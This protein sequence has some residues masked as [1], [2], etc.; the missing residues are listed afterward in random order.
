MPK[1]IPA[2]A[3]ER[4]EKR[5]LDSYRILRFNLGLAGD[6]PAR[7]LLITSSGSREGKSDVAF[8]LA[9][10]SASESCRVILVDAN[11]RR[12]TV[13][14]RLGSREI[15]GLADIL[16]GRATLA[17]SLQGSVIPGL[18]VLTAGTIEAYPADLLESERMGVLMEELKGVADLVVFD[19]PD[20]LS[21]A[22]A[23]IL[24]GLVDSAVYVAREGRSRRGGIRE[25]LEALRQAGGKVAGLAVIADKRR[26]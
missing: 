15:P 24:A 6:N 8:N 10:V 1:R 14:Q 19:A 25:G 2:M 23:R 4:V 11:L 9:K 12:P 17:D 18:G 3:V 21:V 13:H 5:L 16:A 20:A 7:T 22:D 26:R